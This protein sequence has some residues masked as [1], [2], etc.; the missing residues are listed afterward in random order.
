MEE[1]FGLEITITSTAPVT[2][3]EF[4]ISEVAGQEDALHLG[5]PAVQWGAAFR[6]SHTASS[7]PAEGSP[8]LCWNSH[9]IALH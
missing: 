5:R 4:D 3:L 9:C 7:R 2:N 8:V 1:T 6:H